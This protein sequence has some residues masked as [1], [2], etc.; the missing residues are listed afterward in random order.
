MMGNNGFFFKWHFAESNLMV[1]SYSYQTEGKNVLNAYE[2]TVDYVDHVDEPAEV[3][4]GDAADLE[5]EDNSIESVI[6]DPP[7]GDNIMYAEM[8]DAFQVW[9]NEYLGDVFVDAFRSPETNK[10]D[11]AV[12]N[13]VVVS[14]DNDESLSE[15]ARNRYENKMGDIFEEIYRVL[16]P[17]GSLI[18][19][20][21][22]KEVEAW[23][24]LT[25]SIIR[26]GFTIS[27]THTITSE[28]PIRMVAQGNA[29]ADSTLLLTCRKPKTK[30]SERVPTLWRDIKDQTQEVARQKAT[31]LL[32]SDYNLTKTDTIISAF[33]PTLRVFTEEYPVVDNKDNPVRPIDALTEARAAVTEVLIE[34]EL[35]DNLENIDS[36]TTWYI[37]LLLV[38]NEE[39]IPYDE[40][41][42]LG[43]GVGVHVDEIKSN[44]K[45]WGKSRDDLVLKGEDNR[46]RDY[47]ALEAGEKRRKRAYPVNPRD[48]TFDYNV[49]AVHAA[50]NVLKTKGSDFIWNWLK[51]RDLQ[52]TSWFTKTVRSLLQVL[53][54][55][56]SDYDLLINLAS[57]ETGQLLDINTDLLSQESRDKQNRTTLQDF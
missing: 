39:T 25:M 19:Y 6:I 16:E 42:Q 32:D 22:D 41:R 36:L 1:G 12:E 57:G 29:S 10:E 33:G 7:Y 38:Y 8:A 24:S 54:P 51:E 53:P 9:L 40:A 56:H 13:P 48:T 31:E 11:E 45:V 14:P 49:D 15:A 26:A 23:D 28:V 5:C 17:G 18:I 43:L 55:D 50:L 47:T 52:N 4:R 21:T 34:R 3:H 35:D 2:K 27:A 46:V 20:F 30:L 44:T 37:L